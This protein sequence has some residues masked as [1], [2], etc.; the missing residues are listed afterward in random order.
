MSRLLNVKKMGCY[1]LKY[2][3]TTKVWDKCD[4]DSLE[5]EESTIKSYHLVKSSVPL[6]DPLIC[7]EVSRYIF[8][9]YVTSLT[10]KEDWYGMHL[11]YSQVLEARGFCVLVACGRR[12]V[13]P[14]RCRRGQ[15]RPFLYLSARHISPDLETFSPFN[16]CFRHEADWIRWRAV[17]SFFIAT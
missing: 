7:K 3:I 5:S 17:V 10:L 6:D 4:F 15:L 13:R 1:Q 9:Q 12:T 8:K 16:C 14:R 2:S 11:E